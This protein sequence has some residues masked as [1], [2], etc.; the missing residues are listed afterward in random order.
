MTLKAGSTTV[1]PPIRSV[2]CW[3]CPALPGPACPCLPST[4]SPSPSFELLLLFSPLPSSRSRLFVLSISQINQSSRHPHRRLHPSQSPSRLLQHLPTGALGSLIDC[5]ACI[6]PS[7][8]S[9]LQTNG[10]HREEPALFAHYL[11]RASP[12]L[13]AHFHQPSTLFNHHNLQHSQHTTYIPLPS[14]YFGA[15]RKLCFDPAVSR[16]AHCCPRPLLHHVDVQSPSRPGTCTWCTQR[17][18][19]SE[20]IVGEHSWGVREPSSSGTGGGTCK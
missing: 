14:A 5:R 12:Q 6:I 3:P 9:I 11:S 4:S 7:R 8:S 16:I 10:R 2:R 1:P 17:Q 20:R 18:F 13:K 15:G 19:S